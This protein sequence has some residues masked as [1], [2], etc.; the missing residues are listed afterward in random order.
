MIDKFHRGSLFLLIGSYPRKG[1]YDSTM[2]YISYTVLM[3]QD[4]YAPFYLL[5]YKYFLK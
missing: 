2:N 4:L 5:F 1:K 3:V